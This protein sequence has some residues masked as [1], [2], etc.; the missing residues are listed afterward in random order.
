MKSW[1]TLGQNIVTVTYDYAHHVLE[2]SNDDLVLHGCKHYIDG[3][4][5]MGQVRA[6]IRRRTHSPSCRSHR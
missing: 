2:G 5:T 6:S 1:A 3:L 4:R